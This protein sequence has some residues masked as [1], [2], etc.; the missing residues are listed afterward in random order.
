MNDL[1]RTSARSVSLRLRVRTES[2]Q[3]TLVTCASN[4]DAAHFFSILPS[5]PGMVPLAR[6]G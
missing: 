5:Q 2:A 3:V 4:P 1:A 6:R